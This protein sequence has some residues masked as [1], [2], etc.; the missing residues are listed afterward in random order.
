M[1]SL[2]E[3]D[4]RPVMLVSRDPRWE[5]ELACARFFNGLYH[6]EGTF[7]WPDKAKNVG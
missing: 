7:E 3:F 5:H 1:E 2:R 6:G 4:G